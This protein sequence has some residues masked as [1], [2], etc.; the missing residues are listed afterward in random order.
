MANLVKILVIKWI[1]IAHKF[2]D[3]SASAW[4]QVDRLAENLPQ[5]PNDQPWRDSIVCPDS[6]ILRTRSQL[7]CLHE[8]E[9]AGG[10]S[11]S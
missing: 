5:T 9:F 6:Q 2:L 7:I 3:K 4:W 11:D 1:E 8:T 10:R